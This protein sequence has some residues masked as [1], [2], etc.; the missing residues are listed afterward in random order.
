[1][2]E[3]RLFPGEFLACRTEY[4]EVPVVD[5][6]AVQVSGGERRVQLRECGSNRAL[7]GPGQPPK[8]LRGE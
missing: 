8:A 3:S 2:G 6:C 5:E 7:R 4:D 1:M